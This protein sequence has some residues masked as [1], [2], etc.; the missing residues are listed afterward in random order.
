MSSPSFSAIYLSIY[1][2]M[3]LLL[4][5]MEC[6]SPFLWHFA[7]FPWLLVASSEDPGCTK[8]KI[9]SMYYLR[10]IRVREF[11]R[12]ILDMLNYFRSVQRSVFSHFT[13]DL[14]FC[15]LFVC[16]F[17]CITYLSLGFA[18][19]TLFFRKE[20]VEDRFSWNNRR[21]NLFVSSRKKKKGLKWKMVNFYV[22]FHHSLLFSCLE[23]CCLP[24]ESIDVYYWTL[25]ARLWIFQ[26]L[27]HR[28][29]L[30]WNK[31]ICIHQI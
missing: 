6:Q 27:V 4:T 24:H 11:R 22:C 13:S 10:F 15:F 12:K 25:F 19:W 3:Y 26:R 29:K 7:R 16:F 14:S 30:V 28:F 23:P 21:Q 8:P 31:S 17:G 5:E 2:Y 18:F 9:L 20:E 1:L